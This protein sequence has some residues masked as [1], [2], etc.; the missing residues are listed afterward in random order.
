MEKVSGITSIKNNAT[1]NKTSTHQEYFPNI[2]D[3]VT[4]VIPTLNEEEAISHV[5]M[6]VKT[7]GYNHVLVVDG[8]SKDNTIEIV[9]NYGIDIVTQKSK[10]KTGAVK[11][12][13]E[14][15]KTPYFVLIDGDCTYS[16]KDIKQL[17]PLVE[18]NIQ[19]IGAR[20]QGR[21]NISKVNRFGNWCINKI[22]NLFFGTSLTDVCSGLYML[23]T[24]FAKEIPFTT[25]G[26]DVEVEISAFAASRG[27]ISETLVDYYPRVG[28]QKLRPLR[29]GVKIVSTIF[30]LGVKHHPV[31]VL[32]VTTTTM[33]FFALITWFTLS[34]H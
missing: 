2:Y 22:F 25:E 11:A 13:L 6:D 17:F 18:H 12:A 33:L 29:D 7:E 27:L 30:R 34:I 14:H 1:R 9:K 26:F 21:E 31:K 32:T 5:L 10:G 16:A 3:L 4:V 20:T 23:E 24:S 8:N 15:I 28:V 19:V